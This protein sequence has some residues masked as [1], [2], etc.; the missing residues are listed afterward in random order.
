MAPSVVSI[1][2]HLTKDGVVGDASGS[3][4]VLTADG[5]ILTNAHVVAGASAIHVILPGETEPRVAVLVAADAPRDLAIIRIEADGLRPVTFADPEDIRVGDAVVSVGYALDLDGDP[6]VSVGIVSALHR[7][8]S[9]ATKALKGLVQTDAAISSGNSGGP[10]VNALGQVVGITTF[11]ATDEP[12]ISANGVGF[13]ISNAEVLPEIDRLRAMVGTTP[14]P[15]GYVGVSLTDRDDGGVGALVAEVVAGSPAATAGLAVDDVVI[16]ADG[17][18]VT[19]QDGLVA[20]IRAH[21]A[22]DRLVLEVL[23]GG[24]RR[25]VTVTLVERPAD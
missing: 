23:R 2:S 21:R 3:G 8:S 11:I 9:D 22:G 18:P 1:H 7:T 17:Q 25:T 12:G 19:G 14:A 15:D 4:V 16:S 24:S 13:A 6:S 20:V 5:E 10:L